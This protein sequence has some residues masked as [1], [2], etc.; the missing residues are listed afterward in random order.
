MMAGEEWWMLGKILY[1][2]VLTHIFT[3]LLSSLTQSVN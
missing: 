1:L 2:H 3:Y